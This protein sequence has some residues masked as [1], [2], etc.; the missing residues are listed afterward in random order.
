MTRDGFMAALA[1][2]VS[3]GFVQSAQ[4]DAPTLALRATLIAGESFEAP[5][6]GASADGKEYQLSAWMDLPD[7]GPAALAL[8]LDY[9]YTRY[10]YDDIAGRNRDLHRLQLPLR[11]DYTSGAWRLDSVLAPGV[12]T[13]SNVMKNLFEEFTGDD[14]VLTARLEASHGSDDRFRW[15]GG[16]AW[17]RSFGNPGLYPIAGVL[18]APGGNFSARIAF[19]ESEIRYR[20]S[21]RQQALFRVMPAGHEWH[22]VSDELASE[23]DYEAEGW[24]AE[25]FWSLQLWRHLYFDVG[26]GYELG[27]HHQFVDDRG[28]AVDA[29]LDDA[30]A[31]SAGLRLGAIAVARTHT[32]GY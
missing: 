14:L 11:L 5:T 26:A 20:L 1:L 4:A 25:A 6:A 17:D 24:R 28:V 23:F 21:E 22:V 16:L 12:S 15:L 19:P 32:I 7:A 31:L 29:D 2:A 8:G 9:Q 18:Y 30:F 10:E 13:S 3:N 27:R